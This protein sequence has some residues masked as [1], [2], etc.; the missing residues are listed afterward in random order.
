[1]VRGGAHPLAAE[2]CRDVPGAREAQRSEGDAWWQVTA[3]RPER[4][5]HQPSVYRAASPRYCRIVGR[6]GLFTPDPAGAPC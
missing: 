1:M 4:R 6:P 2:R 3:A 5:A